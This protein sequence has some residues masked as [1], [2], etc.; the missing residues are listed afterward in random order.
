MRT[1]VFLLGLI[2][3]PLAVHGLVWLG[4]PWVAVVGLIATSVVSLAML[5]SARGANR[6]HAWLALY[7]LL[8][9]VGVANVSTGSV[10]ALFLPPI[11]VHLGLMVFFGASLR[12]GRTSFIERLMRLEG[13][14]E[15]S[16]PLQAYACRLTWIWTAYFGAVAAVALLLAWRAPLEVWSLFVNVLNFVFIGVLLAL[17][18]LYRWARFGP[19]GMLPPWRLVRRLLRVPLSDR[20]HPLYGGIRK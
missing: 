1:V 3:Y 6:R 15:L 5:A 13:R 11:I 9:M 19:A 16:K 12:P 10:Y 4:V 17:Q 8:A 18:Y 20:A 7:A 14:R 2:V